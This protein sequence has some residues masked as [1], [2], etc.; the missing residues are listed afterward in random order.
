MKMAPWIGLS[1]ALFAAGCSKE[2]N[3]D[4]GDDGPGTGIVDGT[5]DE[6]TSDDVD[7][8]PID[9]ALVN[10]R[11]E[12]DTPE[13]GGVPG[14]G[15]CTTDQ[16]YCG[17]FIQ[18]TTVGGSTHYDTEH[19]LAATFATGSENWD[20]PERVY[21]LRQPVGQSMR[22][23]FYGPCADM[24]IGVCSG[25]DCDEPEEVRSG[26]CS[27]LGTIDSDGGMYR[28]YPSTTSGVREFE[29]VVDGRDGA[30]GNFGL[31]VECFGG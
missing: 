9:D 1:V 18:A 12:Y 16:I 6:D 3:P 27:S 30:Q 21:S 28:D 20:A 25:W 22:V 4:S 10:C 15:E 29:L 8:D 26:D 7:T 2:L 19:Y 14:F 13:P 31:R 5:E 11:S 24:G 23:T 17:D